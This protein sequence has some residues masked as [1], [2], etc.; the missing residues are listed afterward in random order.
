MGGRGA[1][2]GGTGASFR[3]ELRLAD[4]S[5]LE[6]DGTL[7]YGANDKAL[8][9][10]TRHVITTW[11]ERRVKNKIEYAY[12][13]DEQGKVIGESRGGKGSVRSPRLFHTVQN[14]VFTHIHPR[15][16]KSTLG[17]TFSQQ[18]LRNFYSYNNKTMRAVAREG[19]YSISKTKNFNATGFAN[20]VSQATKDFNNTYKDTMSNL[21]REYMANKLEYTEYRRKSAKA[22]N[23]ALV[24]LHR[25]YSKHAKEF[26]YIYTLERR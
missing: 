20:M 25:E 7:K 6:Y 13:V 24:N 4:G 14:S 22:F 15:D 17:G 21:N 23:T 10:A 19:T 8:T 3:G 12:A 2:S 11:E 26:G 5:K 9:G 16:D 18:D 1:T